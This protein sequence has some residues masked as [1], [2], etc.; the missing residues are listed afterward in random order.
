MTNIRI[1]VVLPKDIV[2]PYMEYA[3]GRSARWHRRHDKK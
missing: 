3:D 1:L 2:V